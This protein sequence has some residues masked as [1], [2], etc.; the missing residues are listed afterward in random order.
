M[1]L[2]GDARVDSS[3]SG[4][5]QGGTITVSAPAGLVTVDHASVNSDTTATGPGGDINLTANQIALTNG[6]TISATSTGTAEAL[7]GSIN[8]VFGESLEMQSSSITTSSL[9]ADGGNIS[10]TATGSLLH[11]IDSNITTSVQSGFGGGGNITIGS[12]SHPFDF[13]V[14]DGSQV[15]ADAFGGP[16]GNINVFA[17]VYLT[18][19]SIVSA[20]SALSAPGT[21]AIQ[22]Q[23]TDVS[24]SLTQLPESVLE[25]AALLRAS[26]AAR[27]A[28]GRTS[29][30]VV[31][32]RGGVP[33]APD[34]LL[35]SPLAGLE[36]VSWL[37]NTMSLGTGGALPFDGHVS[38]LSLS[39]VP[40]HARCAW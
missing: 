2:T 14:L 37:G 40:P 30:L 5:G 11:L 39:G 28:E 15:R 34:G 19:T 9:L 10:I 3:T 23:I 13:I 21:I 29:S 35:W 16:G 36:S 38:L 22:A 33:P 32:G 7:A 24:G 25:A 27:L 1:T 26:C 8:I 18:Q 20:S 6:A 4:A 12:E 31:A 17:D